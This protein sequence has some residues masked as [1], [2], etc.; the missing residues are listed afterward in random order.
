MHDTP[1]LDE[2]TY[3]RTMMVEPKAA[4]TT[5]RAVVGA[6]WFPRAITRIFMTVR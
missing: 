4:H 2:V 3:P 6:R 1:V 5:R